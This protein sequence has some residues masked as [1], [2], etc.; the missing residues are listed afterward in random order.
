MNPYLQNE[1]KQIQNRN[2]FFTKTLIES[3]KY[4]DD[5]TESKLE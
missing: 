5:M 3:K 4:L 1:L 2:D